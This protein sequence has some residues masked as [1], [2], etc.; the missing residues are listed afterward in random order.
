MMEPVKYVLFFD[1]CSK[2]NPGR[3]GAGAVIYKDQVEISSE[4]LFVGE[5]ETN[6]VA[7]YTG[8][9]IGLKAALRLKIT[10]L[11]VKGDSELV[12]KHM[13]GIYQVKSANLLPLFQLAQT[14]SKMFATITFQHVFRTAN[15][16]AD[17]LSNEGLL[18]AN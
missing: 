12:I 10:D 3:A 14:L 5:K 1:G 18:L 16:R 11:N 4:A 6:N 8:L 2:G 7:E 13:K 17:A 9:I 15:K